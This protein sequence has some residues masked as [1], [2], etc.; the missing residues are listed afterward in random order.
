MKIIILGSTGM[1]GS[2]LHFLAKKYNNEHI[3]I[4]RN[5]FDAKK[6]NIDKLNLYIQTPCCIVNCIGAI[7]QKDYDNESYT[8]LN[9]TFPL[10]LSIFCKTN[11][12]PL[13]H[14]STNCV[15]SGEKSNYVESDK[16]NATDLY[17]LSK[18]L[19]E[20]SN[21]TVIR[22]SIIG[23]EIN[24]SFGLMEWFLNNTNNNINGYN[25]H[26]WNGLTSLELSKIILN[27]VTE[28]KFTIGIHHYYSSISVSKFELL[29]IIANKSK[30]KS[31]IISIP[32]GT[33]YYTLSSILNEP[34]K[35]I[36][37][38]IDELFNII[39]EYRLSI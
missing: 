6:D 25:D 3:S 33:K 5:E 34:R 30:N 29:R 32:N 8:I 37:E 36:S 19:G 23:P 15:F 10:K 17:G 16:P 2:M 13:I 35:H 20:P 11:S 24:S 12:I 31:N 7:P 27:I 22:C 4:C 26:Y 38:Q 1:L 28:K 21:C 9:T 39:N 14:I 18:Y